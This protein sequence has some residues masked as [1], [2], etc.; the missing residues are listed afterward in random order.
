MGDI[1][2]NFIG[3]CSCWMLINHKGLWFNSE[4]ILGL[5]VVKYIVVGFVEETAFRGWGYN[6]LSK[7]VSHKK[8][9]PTDLGDCILPVIEKG[10][11]SVESNFSTHPI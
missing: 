4:N 2:S 1:C 9:Q 3:L 7:I 8:Q 5:V 10:Q 11:N 6:S